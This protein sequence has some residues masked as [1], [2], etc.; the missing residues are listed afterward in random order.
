MTY[1]S[2]RDARFSVLELFSKMS[3]SK[4][5]SDSLVCNDHVEPPLRKTNMAAGVYFGYVETFRLSSIAAIFS[6]LFTY[7][8]FRPQKRKVNR[9][10]HVRDMCFSAVALNYDTDSEKKMKFN[11]RHFPNKVGYRA[12]DMQADIS[13]NVFY[14]MKIKLQNSESAPVCLPQGGTNVVAA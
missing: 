2:L 12:G 11:L 10:F 1:Q 6:L 7:W 13:Q 9:R 8:L 14:P 3:H 5:H 4:L